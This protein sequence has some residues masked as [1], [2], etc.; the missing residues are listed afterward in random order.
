MLSFTS[1]AMDRD[2]LIL[3][4]A[5]YPLNVLGVAV[6]TGASVF[7]SSSVIKR[8][9]KVPQTVLR[10]LSAIYSNVRRHGPAHARGMSLA[11]KK[12]SRGVLRALP[13][14]APHRIWRHARRFA[15]KE[16]SPSR[17]ASSRRQA[18]PLT[19]NATSQT[20]LQSRGIQPNQTRP[21]CGGFEVPTVMRHACLGA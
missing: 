17:A 20:S 19:L 11:T 15:N 8:R 2:A 7:V 18:Q 13:L 16:R 10:L 3:I 5:D 6:L 21:S 1:G 14:S 9:E 12:S 4:S